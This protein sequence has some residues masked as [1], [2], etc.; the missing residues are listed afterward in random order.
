MA[1]SLAERI[2]PIHVTLPHNAAAKPAEPLQRVFGYGWHS[3]LPGWIGG[4]RLTK[5]TANH[6]RPKEPYTGRSFAQY[7]E[8]KAVAVPDVPRDAATRPSEGP[9]PVAEE[10]RVQGPGLQEAARGEPSCSPPRVRIASRRARSARARSPW[11]VCATPRPSWRACLTTRRCGSDCR[12]WATG[13]SCRSFTSGRTR[14]YASRRPFRRS[15]TTAMTGR[16]YASESLREARAGVERDAATIGTPRP[17]G[18]GRRRRLPSKSRSLSW[19]AASRCKS[20]ASSPTSTAR[21]AP[22]LPSARRS[23]QQGSAAAGRP[24]NRIRRSA[25]PDTKRHAMR[26]GANG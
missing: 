20:A 18:G 24:T 2:G 3:M 8:D 25:S 11:A 16:R 15:I 1:A 21:C 17:C 7:L 19:T 5:K 12:P 4:K 6:G 9:Q 13:K 10:G 23:R 26:F 14:S 22:L